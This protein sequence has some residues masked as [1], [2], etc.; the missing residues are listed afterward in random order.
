[1]VYFI[2]GVNCGVLTKFHDLLKYIIE[3]I[4]GIFGSRASFM[5][6]FYFLFTFFPFDIWASRGDWL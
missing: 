2:T 3:A 6:I 5:W 4:A 1:M